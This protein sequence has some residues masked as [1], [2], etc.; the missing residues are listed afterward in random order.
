MKLLF[1]GYLALFFVTALTGYLKAH[2]VC[3]FLHHILY[4]VKEKIFL[5][6][7]QTDFAEYDSMDVGERKMRLED[8]TALLREYTTTQTI[9]YLISFLTMILCAGM[10]FF[11]DWRLTLFSLAAIPATFFLDDLVSRYEKDINA[12]KRENARRKTGFLQA[13]LQGWR[14]V[15]ALNLNRWQIRH[16]IKYVHVQALCNAR[17]IN[18]WTARVLIIPKIK[19]EF[20]MRFGLYFLGGLLVAKNALHISDL[21]VFVVY[22]EMMANAMKNVST[23]NAQLQS[24]MPM[25]ERLME[26]LDK[27]HTNPP[28]TEAPLHPPKA[29]TGIHMINVTYQYPGAS[30]AVIKDLQLHIAPGERLAIVGKS[31]AGKSTVLKLLTGMLTPSSGQVI[32][33]GS[34]LQTTPIEQVFSHIG[35]VMQDNILFHMSIRENLR[36]GKSD[37]TETEMW[38]ACEM[39]QI[40]E[41]I[42]IL[43]QGLDTIIGEKGLK[44]SGGQRQRMVLARLFLKDADI[45]ILD[46]A[47]SALDEYNEAMIQGVLQNLGSEKTLIVVAH[48]ESSIALCDR[49]VAIE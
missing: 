36:Y 22:Y 24:D 47:T 40:A 19:E 16:F 25:L 26:Q 4:E 9:D 43:P 3:T 27:S 15:K 14:E 41:F 13:S 10:L 49:I 44:L 45:Y 6:Y 30:E 8:D 32:F 48:R 5:G 17:W 46:E 38:K 20:F 35:Y 18:C 42:R 12:V 21:L 1:A 39:A 7:L 11:I 23:A 34:D 28:R 29:F 33:N 37:A 2:S 31:G